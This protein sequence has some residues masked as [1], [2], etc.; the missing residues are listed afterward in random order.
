[1]NV[2]D[3]QVDFVNLRSE[4]YAADSRIPTVVR[5]RQQAYVRARLHSSTAQAIGTPVEDALRRDLTINAL[6]YN[7]NESKIEDLTG[8]ARHG[9]AR[10]GAARLR[11]R[12]LSGLTVRVLRRA[13]RTFGTASS[14]RHCTRWRR[15]WT[16][17]CVRCAPCGLPCATGSRSTQ[18][19]QQRSR[20]RASVYVQRRHVGGGGARRAVVAHARA[21][22]RS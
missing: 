1:M 19:W 2:F 7:I 3:W 15:C 22:R 20:I 6:F 21:A 13:C 17:R 4:S 16:I 9:A 8:K 12:A 5:V 10:R 11:A 14:A 18:R